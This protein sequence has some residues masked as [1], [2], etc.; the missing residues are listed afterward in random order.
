MQIYIESTD[1]E[2]YIELNEIQSVMLD[3]GKE[4]Q[5]ASLRLPIKDARTLLE[6]LAEAVNESERILVERDYRMHEKL[7]IEIA[8][9]KEELRMREAAAVY[10]TLGRDAAE[11]TAL[12]ADIRK[13]GA[14]FSSGS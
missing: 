11:N 3:V 5:T 2:V 10:D 4:G 8:E 1:E 12:I 6:K 7:A 14:E 13:R 9:L